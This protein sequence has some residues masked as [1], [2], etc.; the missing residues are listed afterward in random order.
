VDHNEYW[1][2]LS[3][4]NEPIEANLLAF[5]GWTEATALPWLWDEMGGAVMTPRPLHPMATAPPPRRTLVP[6]S[7]AEALRHGLIVSPTERGEKITEARFYQAQLTMFDSEARRYCKVIDE[8]S[9]AKE[10]VFA[11]DAVIDTLHRGLWDM[12]RYAHVLLEDAAR[13]VTDVPG[14]YASARRTHEAAFEVYKGAE[15]SVYGTYSGMTHM[16]RAP[17][18]PVAVLRTAIELR[19]RQAFG[20][21]ILVDP[22]NAADLIPIDMSKLF[23]AIR[24]YTQQIEFIVDVHDVWKV[25]RWSNLY[26][27]GGF[28]DFPW[29]AGFLIQFL[30]P[31]FADPRTGPHGWNINGGIRMRRQ[32]W[33]AVRSKLVPAAPRTTLLQRLANAWRELFRRNRPAL[34]LPPVDESDAQCV[35]LD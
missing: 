17:Y 8:M 24:G 6:L 5:R 3:A 2:R 34:Q 1:Q 9:A 19:L 7:H 18:T 16:D 14:Y 35:F 11:L 22:A 26:L 30:R 23:E 10:T 29:V 27:H 12:L 33:H 20:V 32:T 25:Y 31:L 21:S 28:R 13:E 15:Q 4:I